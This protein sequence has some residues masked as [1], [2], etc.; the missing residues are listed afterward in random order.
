MQ[1]EPRAHL[2]LHAP[3]DS[4]EQPQP[5]RRRRAPG[6]LRAGGFGGFGWQARGGGEEGVVGVL[7]RAAEEGD[8]E[9]FF[10]DVLRRVERVLD[11]E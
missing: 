8:A 2:R 10:A 1:H 9:R 6:R 5:P 4:V 3:E 7:A 11:R